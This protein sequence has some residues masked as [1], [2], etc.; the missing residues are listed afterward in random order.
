M[1]FSCLILFPSK[2]NLLPII[3]GKC[4]RQAPT[5]SLT[6]RAKSGLDPLPFLMP[7]MISLAHLARFIG[8]ITDEYRGGLAGQISHII[9]GI[10][11][12]RQG[13]Q[14]MVPE[15]VA[16]PARGWPESVKLE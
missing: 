6:L 12:A 3:S 10:K 5:N 4:C 14:D 9:K 1:S 16:I 11:P 7:V 2:S 15:L 8:A 13:L